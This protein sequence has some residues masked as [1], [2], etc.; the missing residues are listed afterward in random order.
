MFAKD[1]NAQSKFFE[2]DSYPIIKAYKIPFANYRHLS[3]N[4]ACFEDKVFFFVTDAILG[5]SGEE[6]TN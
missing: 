5:K 6:F 1:T 2:R 4:F 3:F